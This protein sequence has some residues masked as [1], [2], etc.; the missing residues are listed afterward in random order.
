LKVPNPNIKIKHY[1]TRSDLPKFQDMMEIAKDTVEI[2][3]LDLRII[4]HTYAD[5]IK[6]LANNDI[7]LSFLLLS[8][9][10][11]FVSAQAQ[12]LYGAYDLRHSIPKSLKLLCE[13]RETLPV[14][15]RKN[16]EITTYDEFTNYSFIVIDRKRRGNAWIKVEERPYGSSSNARPSTEAYWKHDRQFFEK[17]S[18]EYLRIF[19]SSFPH[20]CARK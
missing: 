1:K 18:T 17:F 6:N 7:K 9:T 8:P 12:R 13:R 14:A 19:N 11:R 2:L 4:L 5:I 20:V 16:F 10:S 15:K 3:G